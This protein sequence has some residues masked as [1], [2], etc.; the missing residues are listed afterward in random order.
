M[1]IS[2]SRGI[3]I[4]RLAVVFI[5]FLTLFV[6]RNSWLPEQHQQPSKSGPDTAQISHTQA[7]E[8]IHED[9]AQSISQASASQACRDVP[10]A[11]NVM[12]LLK[13]GATELYQKLPTHFVTIFKCI[14]HFMIFSDLEQKFADHSVH[15]AIESVRE[16]FRN[17]HLDF[18]L[19]R[20]LQQYQ[21]EGQDMSKLQGHGSWNLDKWK[22]MPMMHKAFTTAGDNIEWFVIIEADTSLSW[23]NLLLWL[24]TMDSSEPYYMGAQNI[25]GQ[26]PFAH[27]G[28]GVVISRGAADLLEKVR[29]NKGQI[30]YDEEW[31]NIT[32]ISCCG[33][34]VIARA[35]SE[36]DVQLTPAWPLIQGET[37]A[38][39]DWTENHWCTPPVS[40]HHV[41][42]IEIDALWQFERSWIDEHGWDTPYLFRDVFAHFID[43]HV[44][45]NRTKW[46]N[47][48]KDRK[49]AS[50]QLTTPE[51][52][53]WSQL[54]DFE[55]KAVES[56]DS[57]AE[58]CLRLPED[59]CLQWM[60]SPGRCYLG[61]DIRFGKSD[62]REQDH[63]TSG[64]IPERLQ[65]FRRR[66]EDCQI[67]WSG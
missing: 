58:A 9:D 8:Q 3:T 28:S 62:E 17:E 20:K 19:Y 1:S 44:S 59:E 16:H 48:S 55:Q 10:G 64:W 31:E 23:T 52:E 65:S 46:H 49:F 35:F 40:W 41:S 42:P 27:G 15:D 12:V 47:L 37:V 25:I 45:V 7:E 38:S 39:V 18:E 29:E 13:T 21:R 6:L 36:A 61:K 67:R 53:D 51:A 2:S 57:C 22:F 5:V 4:P 24:R 14:P 30:L 11:D 26:T 34:E 66:F 43:R 56:Q 32:S 60:Y 54:K 50:P 33:D 63:W